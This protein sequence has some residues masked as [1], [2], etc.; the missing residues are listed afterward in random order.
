MTDRGWRVSKLK[1]TN[2]IDA[3]AAVVLAVYF[4]AQNSTSIYEQREMLVLGGPD[5]DRGYDYD[6]FS[7][8]LAEASDDP[9]RERLH[10]RAPARTNRD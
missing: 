9:A 1:Q 8:R 7:E 4:A 5:R 6:D 2:P 10:D 3:L